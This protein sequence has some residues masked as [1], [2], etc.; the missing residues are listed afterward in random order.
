MNALPRPTIPFEL[1]LQHI[2][3]YYNAFDYNK[4]KHSANFGLKENTFLVCIVLRV[5]VGPG[6]PSE[7][8]VGIA[9][10]W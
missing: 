8:L 4:S 1:H 3:E 2:T 9:T 10:W 6:G 7:L 5:Q